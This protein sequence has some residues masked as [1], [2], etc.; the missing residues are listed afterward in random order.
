MPI[1][2]AVVARGTT[3]LAKYASCA[4]NFTEVA[5]QILLKIPQENSKLTYS[6]GRE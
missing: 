4:G 3:V 6:H 5:E 2:F 1:L